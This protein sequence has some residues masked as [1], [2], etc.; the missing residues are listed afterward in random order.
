MA[1]L[2]QDEKDE[3]STKFDDKERANI[4]QKQFLSV[5]TKEL[6]AEVHVLNKKTEINLPNINIIEEMIW[7]KILKLN[8]H[9][10]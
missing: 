4:L 9:K 10:S 1:P 2:L 5:L 7:N 8:V 6:N 3:T